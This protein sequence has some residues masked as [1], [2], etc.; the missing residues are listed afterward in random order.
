MYDAFA[1]A[2]KAITWAISS[3]AAS[4][5]SLI[6]SHADWEWLRRRQSWSG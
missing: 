1:E 5:T 4:S 2:T 3:G 6:L